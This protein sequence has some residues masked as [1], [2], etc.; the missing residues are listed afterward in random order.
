M[1]RSMFEDMVEKIACGDRPAVS[2]FAADIKPDRVP[3]EKNRR[4]RSCRIAMDLR[5]RTVLGAYKRALGFSERADPAASPEP[6]TT[7]SGRIANI[8]ESQRQDHRA[9]KADPIELRYTKP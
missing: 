1:T 8:F 5:A 6:G 9:E 4:P 2:G 7:P 3:L